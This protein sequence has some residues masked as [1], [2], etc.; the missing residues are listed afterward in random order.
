MQNY[1]SFNFSTN[2]SVKLVS[3]VSVKGM[4]PKNALEFHL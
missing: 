3:V 1:R 4:K 2:A